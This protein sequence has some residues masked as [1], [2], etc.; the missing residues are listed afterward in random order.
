MKYF[1]LIS[2]VCLVSCKAQKDSKMNA[3]EN[4]DWELVASDAYSGIEEYEASVISDTKSLGKFYS[5][6]NRTRKPGLPLPNVDFS[7]D[8]LLVMCLGEQKGERTPILA[9][10]EDDDKILFTI[11][12][13]ESDDA[14]NNENPI[15]SYPF[16]IY[17]IPHTLKTMN[18]QKMG[19]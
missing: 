2:F 12:L 19:F 15:I 3:N 4:G 11:Q 7:K 17:K 14:L 6:I 9:K 5:R 10:K 13:S 16:Y 18:I 8:V 1:L